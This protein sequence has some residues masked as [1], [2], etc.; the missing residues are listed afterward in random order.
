[1]PCTHYVPQLQRG[2]GEKVNL[3]LHCSSTFVQNLRNILRILSYVYNSFVYRTYQIPETSIAALI[4]RR[5]SNRTSRDLFTNISSLD[6]L[7]K[8]YKNKQILVY[9]VYT[10]LSNNKATMVDFISD[11][12]GNYR[13]FPLFTIYEKNMFLH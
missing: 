7:I 6:P 3:Y 1:M 4:F 5:E 10:Q 9:L 11:F 13:F 8:A 12:N 2:E